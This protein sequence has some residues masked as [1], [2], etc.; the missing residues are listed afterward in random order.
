MHIT[1][2]QVVGMISVE[3]MYED[4]DGAGRFYI[5]REIVKGL[6]WRHRERLVLIQDKYELRIIPEEY[7]LLEEKA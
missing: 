2:L 5:P 4:K 7:Y 3:K 1:V 6:A